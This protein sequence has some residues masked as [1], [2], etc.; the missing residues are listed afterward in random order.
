MINLD[1]DDEVV[2]IDEEV[3]NELNTL[4]FSSMSIINNS[5]KKSVQLG[6]D[7]S[8]TL[9]IVPLT[10]C[11]PFVYNEHDWDMNDLIIG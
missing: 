7:P 2:K 11:P 1:D 4:F 3:H 10:S 5:P 6:G 9:S 8:S